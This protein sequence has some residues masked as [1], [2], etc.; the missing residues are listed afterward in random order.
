MEI[1]VCAFQDN[2]NLTSFTFSKHLTSISDRAFWGCENIENFYCD[3]NGSLQKD[4]KINDYALLSDGVLYTV[5][6]SG[7]LQ[8]AAIPGGK[9]VETLEV[10]ENTARIDQYAGNQNK[11][12]K[13]LILPESLKLIGNYAFYGYDNLECV[14]FR[15]FTA[16]ALESSYIQD[17]LLTEDDP[18]YSILQ[19]CYDIF[20]L[21]LGEQL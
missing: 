8:L 9:T 17:A 6:P 7:K 19:N 3:V 16:P 13:T 5:L 18:G 4:G 10:L 11:N 14:E 2:T 12:I 1:G 21:E 15:S 20:E